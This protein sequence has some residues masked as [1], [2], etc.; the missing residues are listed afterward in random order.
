MGK[1]SWWQRSLNRHFRLLGARSTRAVEQRQRIEEKRIQTQKKR[2]L[3]Q[4]EKAFKRVHEARKRGEAIT[5]MDPMERKKIAK[6]LTWKG[7][8]NTRKARF[9]VRARKHS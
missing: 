7:K 8:W 4:Q 9:D 1:R 5:G 3:E 6:E 2:T